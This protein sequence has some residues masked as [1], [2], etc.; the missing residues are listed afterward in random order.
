MESNPDWNACID[1][2]G[3][4]M[5]RCVHACNGNEE[6]EFDCLNGFKTR[7]LD[8]PCE[9]SFISFILESTMLNLK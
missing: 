9:V 8:C 7:Q 2:N 5:G 4:A 6:C 3:I 1:T